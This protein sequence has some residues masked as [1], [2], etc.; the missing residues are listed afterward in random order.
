MN[1]SAI[2][3]LAIGSTVALAGCTSHS[4]AGLTPVTSSATTG[5]STS[6]AATGSAS[7]TSAAPTSAASTSAA[8]ATGPATSPSSGPS[9]SKPTMTTAT[10]TKAVSPV[11]PP[12]DTRCHNSNLRV[13]LGP[14]SRGA[15]QI[16]TFIV[17]TNTGP[18]PCTLAGHPGVSYVAGAD[19]HQ[20]GKSAA[21]ASGTIHT[22]T[23]ASGET[24]SALL[25]ETNYQNFEPAACKPVEVR[26]LRVYPPGSKASFFVA[27]P[28]KQCS[29][30]SL[31][32]P[33]L[34]VGVVRPGPGK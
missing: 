34:S 29:G 2:A 26:G 8:P 20:V 22:V 15:G 13:G 25:H 9:S 18:K 16:Y 7:L 14:S 17:F 12:A 4:S 3:I 33:A 19:G 6:A 28:G 1:R 21:R 23:L 30:T 10:T 31:P 11:P 24:A 5:A 32:D 27:K